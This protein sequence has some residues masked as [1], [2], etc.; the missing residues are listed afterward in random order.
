MMPYPVF[1]VA[2]TI[3]R[4]ARSVG[5]ELT[6]MQLI[7]LTYIAHGWSLAVT[8]RDLFEDRIEAWKYGPVIP[9][10]YQATKQFGRGRIPLAMVG[11]PDDKLLDKQDYDLVKDV[12]AKYGHL[13]GIQLSDLTHRTGSPW[14]QVYRD[15][16]MSIEIPDEII[17]RHYSDLY[18]RRSAA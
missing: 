11:D 4:E 18:A 12:Y 7:K 13:S 17:R 14:H 2:E 1:Q 6:P 5:R 15:G 10:L 9:A 8:G 16:V 3:L